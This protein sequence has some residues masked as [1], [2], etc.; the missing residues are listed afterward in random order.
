MIH[1]Q[2]TLI[3]GGGGATPNPHSLMKKLK[4]S[5]YKAFFTLLKAYKRYYLE[6]QLFK[7]PFYKLTSNAIKLQ[8][9]QEKRKERL[10]FLQEALKNFREL[11]EFCKIFYRHFYKPSELWLNSKEFKEKYIDTKHP[12]PPLLNPDTLNDENS[13]LNYNNIP[14]EMAWELNLPLPKGYKFSCV[15]TPFGAHSSMVNFLQKCGVS[16][17]K[18]HSIDIKANYAYNYEQ[19][20]S[21]FFVAINITTYTY[22]NYYNDLKKLILMTDNKTPILWIVRCPVQRLLT[23]LN[24]SWG[25]PNLIYDFDEGTPLMALEGRKAYWLDNFQL[26]DRIKIAIQR[27]GISYCASLY[28]FFTKYNFT[29]HEFLDLSAYKDIED[30][31]ELFLRL[32]KIYGFAPPKDKGDFSHKIMSLYE[33]ILPLSYTINGLKFTVT[34]R[35]LNKVEVSEML[36]LVKKDLIK[37]IFIYIDFEAI[38]RVKENKGQ[39]KPKFQAF[40]DKLC[41]ILAFEVKYNRTSKEV[42]MEFLQ[43]HSSARKALKELFG[44]ELEFIRQNSPE[45]VASFQYYQELEKM[46]KDG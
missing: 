7:I 16:I 13:P 4:K 39:I 20:L 31:F 15:M 24:N 23:S 33:G 1:T 6:V 37:D 36:E 25:K 11:K 44:K 12:Y 43:V 3:N 35:V 40:M 18:D 22:A 26:G 2:N 17:Y 9:W 10:E 30:I 34:Y 32:S 21:G 46:C 42:L 14:A 45:L 5:Y 19:A 28:E 38:T 41:Q 29:R 8:K 27:G